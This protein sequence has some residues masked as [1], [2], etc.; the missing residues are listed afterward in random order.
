MRDAAWAIAAQEWR[1]LWR[2]RLAPLLLA[3]LAVLLLISAVAGWQRHSQ[4]QAQQNHLAAEVQ[5]QWQAQPDRHPH[6]VAHYGSY[7][8]RPPAWLSY[9]DP[10]VSRHTGQ[11]LFLEAHRQNG[12]NF[13]EISQSSVLSRFS[14]LSPALI[15]QLLLPLLVLGLGY[16]SIAGARQQG[17]LALYLVQGVSGRQLLL[18]KLLGLAACVGVVLGP[19]LLAL[20]LLAGLS[21]GDLALRAAGF[22]LAYAGW[23]L[24]WLL[25]T[26]LIS[27]LAR[28][29]RS[30]LLGGLALWALLTVVL[31]RLLPEAIEHAL[32]T[33]SRLAQD[34]A[35][36]E[37]LRQLGDSHDPSDAHFARFRAQLLHRYGVKRLEDLPVNYKALIMAEG[38]RLGAEVYNRHM[39]A[40]AGHYQRQRNWQTALGVLTPSLALRS[41][42][43]TL[44]GSDQQHYDDF[45]AK[46]EAYRYQ[47][48]QALNRLHSE[49]VALA[50]DS[51]T[52]LSADHWRRLPG[53]DY[54]A[55]RL[56][57]VASTL[58][59]PALVLGLWL[60]ALLVLL[61]R[62]GRKLELH[63]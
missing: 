5:R 48:I 41:L 23:V 61:A 6:R 52:R 44:A 47:L 53:F 10:G 13:S 14:A 29:P 62:A 49:Q 55:P 58:S 20:P 16:A 57:S 26:L 50:T 25:L 12:A 7:A 22:S 31:P 59:I 46:A 19:L 4:L 51:D 21:G 1:L 33:P 42:S 3:A 45:L 28:T 8:F 15:A 18:G 56:M 32:P 35:I 24:L 38:E 43:M 34:A 36:A 54:Q 17:L 9:L 27:S 39:Q 2:Q 40:L 37:E 30:A 60:A 63:P 11:S